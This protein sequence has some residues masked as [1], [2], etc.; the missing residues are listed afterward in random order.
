MTPH[1]RQQHTMAHVTV[2][3]ATTIMKDAMVT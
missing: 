2:A 1:L 3:I